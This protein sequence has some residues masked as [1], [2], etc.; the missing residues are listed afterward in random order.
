MFLTFIEYFIS[1]WEQRLRVVY[2]HQ[3]VD[4]ELVDFAHLAVRRRER[5]RQITRRRDTSFVAEMQ[6]R[7]AGKTTD[8][9]CL[10][11]SGCHVFDD[12]QQFVGV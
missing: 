9:I 11:L 6:H 10:L 1:D 2:L 12:Y 3:M 8:G 7:A 4:I 5:E